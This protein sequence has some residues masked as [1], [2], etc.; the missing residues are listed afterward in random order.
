LSFFS[1]LCDNLL[2]QKCVQS[3]SEITVFLCVNLIDPKAIKAPRAKKAAKKNEPQ[4]DPEIEDD[5][6]LQF[7]ESNGG[8]LEEPKPLFQLKEDGSLPEVPP[9]VYRILEKDFG[10]KTF[11]PHQA[12]SIMR[13]AC[14]I[15]TVVVLSTGKLKVASFRRES[16]NLGC[17][18]KALARV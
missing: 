14:G 9:F 6:L 17:L 1:F 8:Q 7:V 12:E 2:L 5:E 11:R 13:I 3:L 15:S 16:I 10:H 18:P 4:P